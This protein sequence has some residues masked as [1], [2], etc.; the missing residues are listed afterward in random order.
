[1]RKHTGWFMRRRVTYGWALLVGLTQMPL[2]KASGVRVCIGLSGAFFT[3]GGRKWRKCNKWR[4]SALSAAQSIA[5]LDRGQVYDL[6]RRANIPIR[7]DRFIRMHRSAH[8]ACWIIAT[9]FNSVATAIFNSAAEGQRLADLCALELDKHNFISDKFKSA[10]D[11][12]NL[13]LLSRSIWT[14]RQMKFLLTIKTNLAN[15]QCFLLPVNTLFY[16][17]DF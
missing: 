9:P 2:A 10:P 6:L 17:I 12:L 14:K 4:F 1:L 11:Q 5:Q 13:I 15:G 8:G 3:F 16:T 7:G